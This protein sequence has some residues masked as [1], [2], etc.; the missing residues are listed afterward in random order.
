VK[1]DILRAE[2]WRKAVGAIEVAEG[3]GRAQQARTRAVMKLHFDTKGL[4]LDDATQEKISSLTSGVMGELE[5]LE[6]QIIAQFDDEDIVPARQTIFAARKNYRGTPF[7]TWLADAYVCTALVTKQRQ[8]AKVSQTRPVTA[9]QVRGVL[10]EIDRR[11]KTL[12][13]EFWREWLGGLIEQT[14]ALA[15]AGS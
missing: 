6:K 1:H 10:R 2:R 8:L 14:Q 5:E 3:D 11:R 9:T 4:Y 12:K 13:T 7:D 15:P